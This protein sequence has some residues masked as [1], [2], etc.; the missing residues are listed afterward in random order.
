MKKTL[1]L[2]FI[3]GFK[4]GDDT[5]GGF[6]EHLRALVSHAL[7]KVDVRAIVYPKFETRGD[8]AECVSRFKDWLLEKVIDIEVASSTPSPTIDP[9]VH[10][11]L[12][13]HSMGGIVAADTLLSITYDLAISRP[14]SS[15]PSKPKDPS[16][17]NSLMFPYIS[18]VLA[19][20]TPYLGISPGVVAHG[21]EGH[22]N[23][24]SSALTQ[25]S[26]LTGAIWGSKAASEVNKED[27]VKK[28]P[29]AS[30]P[31]PSATSS[32]ATPAA[33]VVPAWQKWGKLA[34]LAGAGA[35]VAGGAAAAYLKRDQIT[36]GWSWVGSHLEFVGC[37]M[38]G[39]ELRTRVSSLV[40]LNRELGVGWAN[41]YTRLGSK[42][43]SKSDGTTLVGSVV[44]HQRT[45]CN[46]PS[47]RDEKVGGRDFWREAVNDAA[48]DETGAHISMFFPKDNPGYYALSENA[49]SLIADWT[50]N[51]WYE[52]STG[53]LDMSGIGPEPEPE[54]ESESEH[55]AEHMEL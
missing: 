17:I 28:E 53:D 20:D 49:K 51:E 46:L 41:I 18:G 8:L 40:T 1:L 14:S 4:G 47:G 5:F 29:L 3:H 12:I 13:G 33:Q 45:F 34:A 50:T 44:G 21:A 10:T 38:K 25:L 42:A 22:Y 39:E 32:S 37:L 9:S 15:S 6:P 2:C 26:S 16:S 27:K 52:S 35:A 48:G 23:T 11:I 36:A 54:P 7:P 30:L 19:F 55:K 43:L 24:A 31:P